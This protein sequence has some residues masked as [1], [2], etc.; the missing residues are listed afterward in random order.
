MTLDAVTAHHADP[1]DRY[2]IAAQVAAEVRRRARQE[3]AFDAQEKTCRHCLKTKPLTAFHR[4]ATRPDGRVGV[5]RVCRS[6]SVPTESF[7][8]VQ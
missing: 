4:D 2:S 8:V 3:A 7:S 5:C 6:D 1:V